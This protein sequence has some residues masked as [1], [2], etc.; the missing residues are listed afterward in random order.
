M[1][2]CPF[3]CRYVCPSA[4]SEV[5]LRYFEMNLMLFKDEISLKAALTVSSLKICLM[6]VAVLLYGSPMRGRMCWLGNQYTLPSISS[7]TLSLLSIA[8]NVF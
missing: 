3:N 5:K 1:T 8:V 2:V 7:F 6:A 4:S